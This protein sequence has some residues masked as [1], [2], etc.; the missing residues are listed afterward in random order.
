VRRIEILAQL[1]E[2]LTPRMGFVGEGI[3]KPAKVNHLEGGRYPGHHDFAAR[4]DRA[5]AGAALEIDGGR[6]GILGLSTA[7]VHGGAPAHAPP[8]TEQR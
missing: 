7:V 8:L 5:I 2:I 6:F 1:Q 3:P 4:C